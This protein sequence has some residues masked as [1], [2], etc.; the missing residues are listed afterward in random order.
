MNYFYQGYERFK[1][2]I[3]AETGHDEMLTL[4]DSRYNGTH[5]G[6]VVWERGWN[7]NTIPLILYCTVVAYNN[8]QFGYWA[9]SLVGTIKLSISYS[10]ETTLY[11]TEIYSNWMRMLNMNTEGSSNADCENQRSKIYIVE[12]WE[13]LST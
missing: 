12:N 2:I 5:V 6:S 11:Y 8:P 4:T 13:V 9:R 3:L 1:L 10:L 7:S